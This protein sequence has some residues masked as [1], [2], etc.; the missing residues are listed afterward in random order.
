MHYPDLS[1]PVTQFPPSA[2]KPDRLLTEL[3][4]AQ[5]ALTMAEHH[6]RLW[7]AKLATMGKVQ[8]R[9][10]VSYVAHQALHEAGRA[11]DDIAEL[12]KIQAHGTRAT[13]Q[14]NSTHVYTPASPADARG[15]PAAKFA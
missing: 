11:I 9:P 6:V 2:D 12:L 15:E 1:T 3:H 13:Q 7:R 10:R 5:L 14:G 4:E 8:Y